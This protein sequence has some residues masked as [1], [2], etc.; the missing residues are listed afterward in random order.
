MARTEKSILVFEL[1]L[2]NIARPLKSVGI[3][4][5]DFEIVF[6]M[7]YERPQY[8]NYLVRYKTLNSTK[9]I[10]FHMFNL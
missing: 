9:I 7:R 8:N 5:K 3:L 2:K 10:E 6:N 4:F 1:N